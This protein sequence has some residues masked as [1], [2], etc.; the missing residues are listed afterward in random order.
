MTGPILIEGN[1]PI[2]IVADH[3]SNKV[4]PDIDL[5][6]TPALLDEHIAVDIGTDPLTRDL[7]A[8]LG[9]RAVLAGVSRLVIDLNRE[10]EAAGL[11][12]ASSDG[13]AIPGNAGLVNG[14]R[15]RRIERFHRPY[16]DAIA[17]MI[18]A[19]RPRLVVAMHSFTPRLAS[20]PD[21]ARPW[22]VGILYNRDDRAAQAAIDSLTALGLQVGDNEP[23]SG[24][25]LNYTMNRHAEALGLPYINIEVR[26]DELADRTGIARWADLLAEAISATMRTL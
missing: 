19:A 6:I 13:R 18:D 25:V 4:P 23:Y 16:H 9:A 17:A 22:P 2:L 1:A 26:Q 20:R 21:E 5:G 11:I 24:R 14:E 10:P 8:R 15:E 12:P 7:A 3:A